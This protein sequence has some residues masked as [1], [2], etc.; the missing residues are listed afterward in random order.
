MSAYYLGGF[1]LAVFGGWLLFNFYPFKVS[2]GIAL[3]LFYTFNFYLIGGPLL[4]LSK[5]M[6]EFG[7]KKGLLRSHC[8]DP[9]EGKTWSEIIEEQRIKNG[10]PKYPR[11]INMGIDLIAYYKKK[12]AGEN[13]NKK[14]K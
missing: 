9:W 4:L 5:R 11:K 10:W 13:E 7:C 2:N 3:T 14:N 8:P 6:I 12:L 1:I